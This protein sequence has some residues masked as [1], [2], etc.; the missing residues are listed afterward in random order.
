MGR[1]VR[2]KGGQRD[3]FMIPVDYII[4]DDGLKVQIKQEEF[5]YNESNMPSAV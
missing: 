1:G 4:Q 2:G 5:C 3:L